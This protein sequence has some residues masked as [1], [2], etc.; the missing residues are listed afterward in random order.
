M[1]LSNTDDAAHVTRRNEADAAERLSVA[2]AL[3]ADPGRGAFFAALYAHA[4]PD[5]IN[6]YAPGSL[7]AL[8][9]LVH[10]RVLAHQPGAGDVALF[11]ARDED[12]A[13]AENDSVLVAVNDDKPFLFDSLIADV[14]AGG[15]RLRAVF[16]PIVQ[17]GGQAVSVIV[18]VLEPVLSEVRR[19]ALVHSAKATFAQVGIAVRDWRAM[20]LRLRDAMAGLKAQPPKVPGEELSESLALLEWLG[21]NHFTFLGA[22]DYRFVAAGDG[23]LEPDFASGL[24]VLSDSEARV[25]RRGPD[26]AALTPEV[27][28]F[29]TQPA[30]LIITKSNE[31]SLVHRRVHMDYIGI[32]TFDAD[33]ALTGERRFVGLFT[34]SAY[35]RRPKDIPLLRRK[36]AHVIERAGLPPASHD[37][38]AM[39]HILDNY[40]RDELFQ[41][42]EDD[43]FATAQGILRLGERP[44]VRVFLRFDRF[45]RFVSALVFVP[46]DRY[47]TQARERIHLILA[48]ALNGRMS[49]STPTIDDSVLARVHYIIGRNAGA[50]PVVSVHQI[51]EQIGSAIRTWDDGFADAMETVHGE[52]AG[53]RLVQERQAHFSPGYRGNFSPMDAA[54]DLDAIAA[55]ALIEQG[56]R[57]HARVYRKHHDAHSA[58]RLKLY[59]L[60]E[61]MPLSASLP[62]FENLGLKV[63]A[64]DSFPVT[65]KTG[66]GWTHEANVLDF[67]MERSDEGAA[68]LAEIKQ[69]LEDAFHAVLAG[70]CES[71]GFNRLVLSAGLDWR[72]VTILRTIAKFLRQA[73]FAFSQDYVEH[74]LSR[75]PD[76]ARLL[77]E[78]FQA[79]TDPQGAPHLEHD[80]VAK[81]IDLALN[82]V[83]SLD[84]DRII[85]RLRNVIDNVLRTNFH[86]RDEAGAPKPAI[87]VKLDSQKL[88]DLPLPRP[89]V[90]IFVYAPS[91]EGVHL[92][93]GRIARGGIRWSD[94]R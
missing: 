32:K 38:K 25:I 34:S 54:H 29:L 80:G 64:E 93:F 42:S 7:A 83:A 31:R 10:A 62:I 20:M 49:A 13:Y 79:R 68:D 47:D 35:S 19:A 76:L 52:S 67:L 33:G 44:A 41:I 51:E 8:A 81:R 63:I 9:G 85:R 1:S 57:V 40:P 39:T 53:M 73:G 5:D 18:L 50:R 75:N 82:D 15:G 45:D 71:D 26:R 74:A 2:A 3:V 72:D 92:R 28:A 65:L 66:D 56:P 14:T 58:L 78:L 37:G 17:Q 6:R 89:H 12:P 24:G 11:C 77:V 21:D 87:A 48:N 23:A 70:Q 88:D 69:P 86:Q 22:R 46:R 59:I 91:V 27:R 94:R 60:G 61:V 90:E 16:H 36:V 84:D 30:P 55:L 43:L 4:S